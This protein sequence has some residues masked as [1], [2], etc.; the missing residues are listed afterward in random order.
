MSKVL[1]L[2]VP[3]HGN[4]NPTL[5]LVAELIA[6]GEEVVYFSSDEF[7]ERIEATGAT[8]KRYSEDLD[9]FK[10]GNGGKNGGTIQRPMHRIIG[11]A[12]TIIEDILFQIKD[13]SFDYIIH[14]MAF[15]F[16]GII[17]Q[18]L[19]LPSVSSLA[20]FSGLKNFMAKH[21]TARLKEIPG[22]EAMMKT[23][24]EVSQKIIG[25]YN[26]EMPESP[27]GLLFNKGNLNLIYTSEYFIDP[28]D[29]VLFDDTYK[30]VGPP[31]YDRKEQI[32]F[33][34]EKLEQ[35]KVIYISLGTVFGNERPDIYNI[36]FESF[37]DTNA[38]VVMAAYNVDLSTLTI[39]DHFIVRNYVPQ[40]EILKHTNVA[41]THAGMNSIS[42]L[43]SN[44]VPFVALPLGAD[45][46]AL[47]AR[48]Q[49]LGAA[50]TLDVNTLT[51]DELRTATEKVLNDPSYLSN[52]RKIAE[53]FN[54]A[55]GYKKAV[56][57][58][59]DMMKQHSSDE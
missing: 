42:D 24:D 52:I 29:R 9:I 7:K 26:V 57:Y 59:F 40:S 38:A 47:A 14:S 49:A 10:A 6:R 32:D 58:I 45:Q 11:N 34:F 44:H 31:V 30:F 46:P 54:E 43:I 12:E 41:I 4:V 22:M 23:Y 5:G 13:R 48:S 56:T 37:A 51:A 55:G 53:S 16:A 19:Q 8:F 33:P 27:I 39:P 36:F 18:I 2:S 28:V 3:A 50:I 1:F 15:P 35:K 17:K 20:V 25:N 21:D